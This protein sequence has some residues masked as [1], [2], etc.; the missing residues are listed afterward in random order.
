MEENYG[1]SEV[2][3][4]NNN[5]S[6][7]YALIGECLE[8]KKGIIFSQKKRNISVITCVLIVKES[9]IR[10]LN[11]FLQ[12]GMFIQATNAWAVD[13]YKGRRLIWNN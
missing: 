13:K 2:N 10:V 3:D 8:K 11:P 12:Y 6:F 4:M 7:L 9:F 5:G 1:D